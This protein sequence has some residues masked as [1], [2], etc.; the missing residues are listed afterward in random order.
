MT[1]KRLQGG[2]RVETTGKGRTRD[3]GKPGAYRGQVTKRRG[4]RVFVRWDGLHF[5]DEMRK[6]EVREDKRT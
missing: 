5:E 6:S 2:D 1:T 4:N 3:W